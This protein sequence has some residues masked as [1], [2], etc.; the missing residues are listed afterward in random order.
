MFAN[1]NMVLN[2]KIKPPALNKLNQH[3]VIIDPDV[4][5]KELYMRPGLGKPVLST[6]QLKFNFCP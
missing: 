5:D 3:L 1:L 4:V 6:Y 2:R